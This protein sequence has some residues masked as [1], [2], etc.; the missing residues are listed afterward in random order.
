MPFGLKNP[1]GRCANAM[2]IPRTDRSILSCHWYW[3]AGRVRD[4]R[5]ELMEI[6]RAADADLRTARDPEFSIARGAVA[7]GEQRFTEAIEFFRR[8]SS[9][10]GSLSHTMLSLHPSPKVCRVCV[11]PLLG[12]AYEAADQPDSAIAIYERFLSTGDPDRIFPDGIWRATVLHRLG[13]LHARQG[14]T[15]RATERFA[16]FV[17]LWEHADSELQPR[18]QNTRHRLVQLRRPPG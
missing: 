12:R 18:V 9:P 3:L 2:V 1:A 6:E 14:D 7:L 15:L 10:V 11:L 5:A 13:D 17:Q 8:A 16:Q 4:A